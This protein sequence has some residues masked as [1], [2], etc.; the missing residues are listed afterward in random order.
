MGNAKPHEVC[1]FRPMV[2]L[3]FFF[4]ELFSQ[5]SIFSNKVTKSVRITNECL[6][7]LLP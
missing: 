7:D 5:S 3:F 2:K 4:L 1:L 6:T